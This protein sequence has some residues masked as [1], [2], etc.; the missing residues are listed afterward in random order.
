VLAKRGIEEAKCSDGPIC[1][2]HHRCYRYF[3]EETLAS[4]NL[5]FL[6]KVIKFSR[7]GE[8]T[9]AQAGRRGAAP[10]LAFDHPIRNQAAATS[11]HR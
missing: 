11:P 3:A 9:P 1:K 6:A 4:F 2:N 10:S 8:S 7:E 5:I